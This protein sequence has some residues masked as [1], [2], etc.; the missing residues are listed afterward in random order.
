MVSGA[1]GGRTNDV[2]Q[3]LGDTAA[4]SIDQV[5]K[6]LPHDFPEKIGISIADGAK[7]LLKSLTAFAR[8]SIKAK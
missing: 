7:R 8:R 4:K 3:Q 1:T 6:A 2:I 5:L